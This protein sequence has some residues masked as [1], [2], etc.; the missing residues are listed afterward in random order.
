M[1]TLL[2][3]ETRAEFLRRCAGIP[4]M[5]PLLAVHAQVFGGSSNLLQLYL[6]D[7]GVL[8]LRGDSAVLLGRTDGEELAGLLAFLGITSLRTT[9]EM[10]PPPGWHQA[11]AVC[12]MEWQPISSVPLPQLPQGAVLNDEPAMGDVLAVLAGEGVQGAAA[13]NLYSELCSKR[14]RG[15][16]C[17]W[18][19]EENGHPIAAACAAAITEEEAYLSEIATLP[20][21]RGRGIGRALVAAL[22]DRLSAGGARRVTLLC[23][24]HRRSFYESFGFVQIGQ[25]REL[26]ALPHTDNPA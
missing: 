14:S 8:Q 2:N 24:T 17:G 6:C 21:A 26:T 13:E 4:C 5:G 1:I 15:L 7:E 18:T 22:A 9:A 10:P 19:V 25:F 11:E 12:V 16:A 23:G 3:E 20:A